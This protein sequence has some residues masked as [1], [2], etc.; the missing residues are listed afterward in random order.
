MIIEIIP[1]VMKIINGAKMLPVSNLRLDSRMPITIGCNTYIRGYIVPP[2]HPMIF[3]S[4]LSGYLTHQTKSMS[5]KNI[6]PT[7]KDALPAL[8]VSKIVKQELKMMMQQIYLSSSFV[9]IS[10]LS[11]IR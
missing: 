5:V 9:N 4:N 6:I 7:Y 2:I 10:S 1:V 3:K 8:T 11:C